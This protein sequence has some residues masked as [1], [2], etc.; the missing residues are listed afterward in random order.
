M[1]KAEFFCGMIIERSNKSKESEK[2]KYLLA[3]DY[4]VDALHIHPVY[5]LIGRNAGSKGEKAHGCRY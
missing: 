3:S 4:L 2:P 1:L 5:G